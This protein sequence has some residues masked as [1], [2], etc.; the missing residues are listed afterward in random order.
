LLSIAWRQQVVELGLQSKSPILTLSLSQRIDISS[1]GCYI[2]IWTNLGRIPRGFSKT[3]WFA[4]AARKAH[5]DDDE[6]CEAIREVLAGQCDDLGGGVFKKR[7]NRNMHRGILL[8]KNGLHWIYAYIFAKKDR[9]S[10]DDAELAGF[11]KLAKEYGQLT[12]KQLS[13]LLD[14]NALM[15]ICEE[16]KIQE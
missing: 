3:A 2:N 6:L 1:T 14:D 15:E 11:R 13:K 4:K 5:I 10:I 9:D 12:A 8:S 16:T 7:L